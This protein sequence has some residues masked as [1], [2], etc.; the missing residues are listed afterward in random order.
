MK[1][2][3]TIGEA[4]ID[5]IPLTQGLK[6]KDVPAFKPVV[7]GAPCNVA[8][9]FAKL[10]GRSHLISKLGQDAF[11]DLILDK[12]NQS[13]VDTS[14]IIQTSDYDTSLAF[15]SLTAS[16]ERDFKFYRRTAADLALESSELHAAM[17]DDVGIVHFCS[18]SLV[19]SP[20]K[21]AHQTL[22]DSAI[23][24]G[25]LISFD[26]NLRLSLWQDHLE[27]KNTVLDFMP[28]AHIL[29]ISDEE[30]EF[31]TGYTSI[32]NALSSLFVGNVELIIYTKGKE[33]AQLFTKNQGMV[34]RGGIKV[35]VSDTTGAGDSFIG[36]FL[37]A[38][39][40]DQQD[41]LSDIKNNQFL[42]YLSLANYYA[43]HTTTK[44]GA[45]DAMATYQELQNFIETHSD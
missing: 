20:M 2:L 16:G 45:I 15:V 43:A 9:A 19:D 24:Q 34:E 38:L 39:M 4:L 37:Y 1:K 25:I 31:I 33:G 8:A 30:L 35:K 14:Y 18:V 21:K 10:G 17:L 29:K 28:K 13:G 6:L 5:F 12:L 27:L 11:G 22:I 41:K 44:A 36:A 7:G 32:E 40:K 3:C 42:S 26:P 23:N